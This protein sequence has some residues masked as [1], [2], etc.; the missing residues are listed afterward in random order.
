MARKTPH[1]MILAV[2]LAFAVATPVFAMPPH[3]DLLKQYEEGKRPIPDFLKNPDILRKKGINQPLKRLNAL[4]RLLIPKMEQPAGPS[5]NFKALA[6]LVD[7]SDKTKQVSATYFDTLLFGAGHGTVRDYYNEVSY[8]SLTIV[9]VNLP[10]AVG[11]KRAPQTYS[12]YT[13]GQYGMGTYPHNTQKLTEDVVDA[14]DSVV[15]FSQYDNDHDGYVDAL[16]IVHAGSGAEFSGSV[17]DI[18][19][20]QWAI[21]P[22][23]KDGV[24]IFTYSIEPEY[25]LT[26]GDMTLGVYCHEL[27]HVFGLPDLYDTDSTS[28]GVG[29]WSLMGNG[30]WNGNLGDSP[31]H[32]DAWSRIGLGF[33]SPVVL[34]ENTPGA[35]I[36]SIEN[37]GPIYYLWD[38]GSL[39]D[40]Y[41]LVENR[42]FVGYDAALPGAGLL[43]W[44]VDEAM[45]DNTKECLSSQNCACP[46]H[47]L[48]ALEQADGL[49][50]LEK[51]L[52]SGN[53]GDPFPGSFNKRTFDLTTTPNSGSYLD[54]DS[55]VAV[56]NIS[57]SAST[58]TA[59]LLVCPQQGGLT[60]IALQSP[61]DQVTFSSRPT[62][63]WSAN[64]GANDVFAIDLSYT[65]TFVSTWS[66][67]DNMHQL[68]RGTSW[69]LP[70]SIWNKIGSGSRVYWRVRG[71]DLAV[72]PLSITT[73]GQ[74]RSFYKQ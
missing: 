59:D 63:S 47:F 74:V 29:A 13:N 51:N 38:C 16:F 19:S 54:C 40:E 30:S 31:A 2:V 27:G 24:R 35:A 10:S 62:F 23:L 68:I 22:R 5:G 60:Q 11:W 45:T 55:Q 14:V 43:I 9:T 28:L 71:A 50:Q 42:Q 15:D 46:S 64:G 32:P 4:D 39:N 17:N 72:Q 66:S 73:S 57:N 65:P 6:L 56:R 41:F 52:N 7:F 69:T 33:A 70:L 61:A 34:K 18:W 12:Y 49:L 1:L 53:T 44:H 48:V 3:P 36:L 20:H 26:A 8:G 21:P 67:Y 37:H 58:M 25:W